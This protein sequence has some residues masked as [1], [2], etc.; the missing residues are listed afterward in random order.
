MGAGL[1]RKDE[2]MTCSRCGGSQIED[3]STDLPFKLDAHK[4]LV[5]KQAPAMVCNGCGEIMLSDS[6]M[7]QIDRIIEKL[8]GVN[9]EL[10]VVKFAA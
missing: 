10:E 5:V 8:H 6:V 3:Q 2:F 7:E 1:Q 9:S 4:I